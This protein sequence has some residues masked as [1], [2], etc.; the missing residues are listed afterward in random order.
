MS[1]YNFTA[2]IRCKRIVCK[3]YIS[4]SLRQPHE[5]K[6]FKVILPRTLSRLYRRKY[7]SRLYNGALR[8]IKNKKH[9]N[10]K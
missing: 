3:K 2:I 1:F 10:D 6:E 7:L 9:I 8:Q 5:G 4:F